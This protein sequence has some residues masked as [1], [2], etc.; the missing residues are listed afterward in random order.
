M[1]KGWII[2]ISILVV[3][4]ILWVV[5]YFLG[6]KMQ[7]K[8]DEQQEQIQ[9]AAQ[10]A[11]LLIID[12]KKMKLKDANLPKVVL[13]QVPKRLR[14]SKVPIVKAKVG[15][16][17]VSLICDETIFDDLPV[18]REVKGMISGIYLISVK[19][20][21][22]GATPQEEKKKPGLRAR[23]LKKQRELQAE[24]KAEQSASQEEKAKKKKK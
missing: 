12:K 11:S 21:R 23:L 1:S 4:I 16:Q 9:A 8:Q 10:S 18:K 6:K 17:I 7:K 15:P 22:G 5:M 19:S 14:G 13:D 24:L 2:A 3:F 20:I